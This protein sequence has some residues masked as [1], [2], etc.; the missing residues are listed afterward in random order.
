MSKKGKEQ[1]PTVEELSKIFRLKPEDI[2]K[3]ITVSDNVLS[4]IN[5]N[6]LNLKTLPKELENFPSITNLELQNNSLSN[7]SDIKLP[8]LQFLDVSGN[9]FTSLEIFSAYPKLQDINIS[10]NNIQ[11]FSGLNSEKLKYLDISG[12]NLDSL[13]ESNL[14]NLEY[15]DLNS[16]NISTCSSESLK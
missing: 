5:L 13:T 11:T 9:N 4:H 6:N 16:N 2:N 1:K 8:N 14:V 15:L 3:R 10:R 12:N 7:L